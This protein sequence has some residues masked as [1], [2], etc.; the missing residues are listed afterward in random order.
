MTSLGLISFKPK[1]IRVLYILLAVIISFLK[2]NEFSWQI[3][4]LNKFCKLKSGHKYNLSKIFSFSNSLS[5]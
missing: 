3:N 1:L 2:E 4:V 5:I